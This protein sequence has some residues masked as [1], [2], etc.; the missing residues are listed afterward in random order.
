MRIEQS[1][2][3]QQISKRNEQRIKKNTERLN[4]RRAVDSNK[5][6]KLEPLKHLGR[7][8]PL[9]NIKIRSVTFE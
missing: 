6:R 3:S 4:G 1:I 7:R 2:S 9:D 5:F 8:V